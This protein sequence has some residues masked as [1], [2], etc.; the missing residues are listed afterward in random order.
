MFSAKLQKLR[1]ER[2]FPNVPKYR[3]FITA[4]KRDLLPA[5]PVLQALRDI[6]R[7]Q[8]FP[9]YAPV[10]IKRKKKRMKKH[11]P[12]HLTLV[13]LQSFHNIIKEIK[14]GSQNG[15]SM[16]FRLGKHT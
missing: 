2:N 5:V 12:K 14:H 10:I 15:M 9:K 11:L 7:A 4:Q 13:F 8:I 1:K 16:S 3:S 6:I